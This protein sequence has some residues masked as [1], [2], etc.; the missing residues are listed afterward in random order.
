MKSLLSAAEIKQQISIVDVLNRLGYEPIRKS[1]KELLYLSMLRD[2][3]SKPSFCVNNELNAWFDHGMG[4]GG[5]V[6]DF[7]LLYWKN[8]G[9]SEV[10]AEL[11]K[12]TN[13]DSSA[14]QKSENNS[15]AVSR[16][17]KPVKIPHY[18]VQE[19]K[20]IGSNPFISEYLKRRGLWQV[21]GNKLQ[22]VYYYVLDNKKRRKEFFAAGWQN[23]NGGWEV[24]NKYFKGCLGKKG[25]TVVPGSNY[26]VSVFEGYMN[27]LSWLY[28]NKDAS[29]TIL[30]LNSVAFLQA[31]IARCKEFAQI[32]LF[33]DHDPSGEDAT[34]KFI[35]AILDASDCSSIYE[36]YNDYNDKLQAELQKLL[37]CQP[38]SFSNYISSLKVGFSR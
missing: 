31:G 20:P 34:K 24:R 13:A 3:D 21:A 28:E 33:F 22:E 27:Y 25:M 10:L 19:L 18:H 14:L 26:K 35:Q 17:K 2:S 30:V 36:G 7:G 1:G 12:I 23:E 5:N 8:L 16:P 4:K 32:N 37:S 38:R 11:V 9:F 6:V 29:D 15:K